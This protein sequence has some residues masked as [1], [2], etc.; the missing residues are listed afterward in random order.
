MRFGQFFRDLAERETR[1]MVVRAPIIR[2]GEVALPP[3]EYGFDELYCAEARC[4][5]RRVMLNVLARHAKSHVA[6]INHGFEPPIHAFEH[7]DQTFLDPLNPQSEWSEA[8]LELFTTIVLKDSVY[9][10]RL[11]RHYHIFKNAVADPSHPCQQ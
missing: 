9:R 4:D 1:T 6:T 2:N 8:L 10:A 5:C 3:D 11:Q 7:P